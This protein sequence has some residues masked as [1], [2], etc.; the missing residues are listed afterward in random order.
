MACFQYF[1][2][3]LP[4]SLRLTVILYKIFETNRLKCSSQFLVS[5]WVDTY[6][7][8]FAESGWLFLKLKI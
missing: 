7:Q 6:Q 4:I 2:S 5:S 3:T 8:T 1:F